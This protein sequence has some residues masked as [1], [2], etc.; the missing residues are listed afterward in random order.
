MGI[1]INGQTDTISATD[2]SLNIGGTVTVNV[3]GDAT[4]LTG[5]PDIT[6]GAVTASSAIIS[7]DLTVNGTTTTLDT[8]LTEVDKLEVGANNT[9]VGVAITQSGSGD[10]LRLYDGASQVVTV[11][12]GG[13][14]LVGTTVEGEQTADDLTISTSGDTGMT[15]RSGDANK[16][17]IFFSDATIGVGEYR[18]YIEYNHNGDELSLGTSNLTRLLI[19]SS[20][21]VGIGTDN[22]SDKLSVYGGPISLFNTSTNNRVFQAGT[23]NGHGLMKVF[24]SDTE[25]FLRVD[26]D[27]RRFGIGTDNPATTFVV[28]KSDSS[29][30]TAH[31][32]V[33]N[34]ESSSG[35][36]LLGAGS[37]FSSSGWPAITDAAI[38]RSSAGSANG[39]AY[40]APNGYHSF[41]SGAGTPSE[42]LRIDSSGRLLIGST[43]SS[44]SA[45]LAVNGAVGNPEAFFELN[46][47]DDPTSG[48]NIGIIEFCQGNAASRLAAR[49]ITR[50]DGGVWGAS[51]LPTR[52]EFHTCPD[53]SNTPLERLRITSSGIINSNNYSFN[54]QGTNTAS[55]VYLGA[56]APGSSAYAIATNGVER[57]RITS[58]GFVNVN[59]YGVI[60]NSDGYTNAQLF[61]YDV[62]QGG[63]A[64]TFVNNHVSYN[65]ANHGVLWSGCS[66]S[67]SSGYVLF[68]AT[69]GNGNSLNY[70]A[71]YEFRLYGDGN[72]KCDGSWTGGGADYAEMFEWVDGNPDAEDR[73]GLSVVLEGNKIRT[74][75]AGEDP[76]GVISANPTIL[77]DASWNKW[78]E[79]HL[80]DDFGSYILQEH[81]VIE[82]TDEEGK[83]H[84]YEDWNI[85]ADV[86]VPDDAV[87]TTHDGNGKRFT[88]R[89]VNPAYDPDREYIPREERQEWDAVG[90][91]GKLRIRKG[92][93]TGARWIKMRDIS[94]T[95]EE[96]LVR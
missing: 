16:G 85:P 91:M 52:F 93:V 71:D 94:E 89:A 25:V 78:T 39:I 13:R 70:G 12:D 36:S 62:R 77:G 18:G 46:R 27:T 19:D 38:I 44:S 8:T 48:Q 31:I 24:R 42:A 45:K 4:G 50:R 28:D 41:W 67:A 37:A 58:D 9:T 92:Q 63:H 29:G 1:Q 22:P 53:G 68:A 2:G 72:G 66:R 73:R 76:I 47:T 35:L 51:S 33:N 96:W 49:I 54:S 59:D 61:V 30:L 20:G 87:I 7:G 82:W 6:V 17:N 26:S 55:S 84:N 83:E 14:L 86:V 88:H 32:L 90:L 79:K 23:T 40:H 95:V 11:A 5:T 57:F 34:S 56:F 15:I 65:Q 75:V 69:S 60:Y 10:I 3:T 80:R 81:N 74:A 43:S 64:G 21:N